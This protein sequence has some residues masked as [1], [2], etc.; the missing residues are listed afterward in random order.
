MLAEAILSRESKE[1]MRRFDMRRDLEPL[2]DLID[3]AFVAEA[4]PTRS[5]IVAEMRRLAKAGPLLW[6]LDASYA[7][8]SP[9][10]SGF[11]WIS[12]N[13]LVGNVT[14]SP[15]GGH[16]GLWTVSNVAVHPGFRGQG[17]AHQLMQSALQ[18]ARRK[19][20]RIILLEVQTDNSPA[21]KLYRGL[22]F[23]RYDAIAELRL[24]ALR[25]LDLQPELAVPLRKRSGR[26]WRKLYGF[27]AAVTPPAALAIR[28]IP[29][30]HYRM[31]IGMRLERLLDDFAYRC[32]RS[33]WVCDHDGEIAAVLQLTGQYGSAAHRLQM[34]V[35]PAHRGT[36]EHALLAAG[37][38][39]LQ[40]FPEREVAATASTSHPQAL[41]AF[42]RAGF[43]TV[44]I[45]DQMRAK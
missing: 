27:F 35:H 32:Q 30:A 37:L 3:T 31:D 43:R 8:L 42:Q 21:Q 20:A 18:E 34:D 15:E 6:L 45:L 44:R 22:G 12:G 39:K 36:L 11:V 9:L 4:E 13:T 29:P 2:A 24:P 33:D 5:P 40:S 10:M 26:D 28:P 41:E 1:G 23:E 17:I 14:L 25:R 19:G 16:T 38:H 7:G